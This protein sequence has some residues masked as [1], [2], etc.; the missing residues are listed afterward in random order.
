MGGMKDQTRAIFATLREAI[1]RWSDAAG[2]R[3]AYVRGSQARRDVADQIRAYRKML[4][5]KGFLA[6]LRDGLKA[7][8]DSPTRPVV[9]KPRQTS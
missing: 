1:E 8:G 3:D 4:G 6:R 2:H 9:T 7:A 5:G